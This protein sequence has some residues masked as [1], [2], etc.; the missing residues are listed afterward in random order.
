MRKKKAANREREILPSHVPVHR[1]FESLQVAN[2]G[3][4]GRLA[5]ILTCERQLEDL[6]EAVHATGAL[7]RAVLLACTELRRKIHFRNGRV[8]S[9][10]QFTVLLQTQ[11]HY[12]GT[13]CGDSRTHSRCAAVVTV[14]HQTLLVFIEYSGVRGRAL[15]CGS[16]TIRKDQHVECDAG[17]RVKF[18]CEH[19]EEVW[20]RNITEKEANLFGAIDL[21]QRWESRAV[22]TFGR[23]AQFAC[24]LGTRDSQPEAGTTLGLGRPDRVIYAAALA[25]FS[26]EGATGNGWALNSGR[27]TA[28]T[29][30]M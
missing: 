18:A 2:P 29:S 24:E 3:R 5:Y 1:Q 11:I 14:G 30:S 19:P 9:L 21:P 20:K 16:T 28:S 13:R 23:T 26:C 7:S 4:R 10:D 27:A 6:L 25:G 22:R 15:C 12:R 17:R 8:N